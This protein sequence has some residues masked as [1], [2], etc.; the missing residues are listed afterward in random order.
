MSTD[1]DKYLWGDGDVTIVPRGDVGKHADTPAR[2][3]EACDEPAGL[4]EVPNIKQP[5]SFSCGAASAMSV[6]GFFGVG[7]SSL[8]EWKELLGTDPNN[9][10][11][12]AAIVRVLRSLGLDVQTRRNMTLD[13]LG[14]CWREGWPVIC[15]IQDYS[16]DAGPTDYEDGHYVI[17]VGVDLGFVFVQDSM[18]DVE[19][20]GS[21]SDAAPGRVMIRE[22]R[23]MDVWH[24]E[25]VSGEKFVRFGIVVKG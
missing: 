12:P 16:P 24:D 22:Q 5:D 9:G 25:G 15:P 20:E 11:P 6:G 1:E 23:F 19:L 13:D 2:F 14:D 10:T 21:N 7:P 8:D 18:A 4:L 17:V 3:A